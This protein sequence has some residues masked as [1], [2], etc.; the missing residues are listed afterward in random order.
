MG[1]T[2]EGVRSPLA[3]SQFPLVHPVSGLRLAAGNSGIRYAGR[4]DVLFI[5]LPEGST[6][7]GTLTTSKS[8]SAPV[9]WCREKLK[10]GRALG[11]VIN[12]GNANA[13]TGKAG[14]AFVA[15]TA[16]MAA[17]L[18]GAKAEEIFIASTGTIGVPLPKDRLARELPRI[19]ANLG[20]VDIERA[21]RAIM[22][23]DTFPK[24]ASVK[25][26]LGGVSVHITGIA[27]GAG[28]IAPDMATL[29]GF[30]FTDA[31][32]SASILRGL[33]KDLVPTT[34]NS[35]TVDGDTSTSDTLL[36]AATHKVAMKP[37]ARPADPRLKAFRNA[38]YQVLDDLALQIVKD[39]E[40]AQKLITLEVSGAESDRA[41]RRIGLTIANSPLVKTAIAGEDANWGRIVAAIGRAGEKA[42]RDR[43]K[44]RM[45]G[46]LICAR[47][48]AVKN[49]DE[50][51]VATHLKSRD[52]RIQVELGIGK[53]KARIR[54]CDLTHGYIDINGAYRT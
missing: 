47:G 49:Y 45:G 46:V 20:K 30:V 29:L 43:I 12:A 39:G 44:I 28:M 2:K 42:D 38:L 26:K 48:A 40:G 8:S 34:F 7:A 25:V 33:L 6:I 52:V 54:T 5:A 23:T 14:V 32:I 19:A 41:A 35:I 31:A 17:R 3:P 37:I 4:D 9:D 21:A 11:I 18:L 24:A 36:L 16:Q 13:F 27:K 15:A 1:K 50:T 53:G 22:T 51:P 10:H